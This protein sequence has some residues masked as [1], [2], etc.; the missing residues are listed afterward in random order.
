M[1][2]STNSYGIDPDR[3]QIGDRIEVDDWDGG[4][5]TDG[6]PSLRLPTTNITSG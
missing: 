2:D 6:A 5:L 3:I 1:S 4:K